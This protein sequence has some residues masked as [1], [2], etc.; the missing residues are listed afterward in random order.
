MISDV[1]GKTKVFL[2]ISRGGCL[3]FNLPNC[4]PLV[5]RA[6][7]NGHLMAFIY[8]LHLHQLVLTLVKIHFWQTSMASK[9]LRYH[10]GPPFLS[11]CCEDNVAASSV[12]S[13]V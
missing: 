10:S 12:G 1:R 6:Y 3:N 8:L 11:L 9:L 2:D 4:L 5:A 13:Q 7:S